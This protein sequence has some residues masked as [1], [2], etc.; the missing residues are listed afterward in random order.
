MT[1]SRDRKY[2]IVKHDLKSFE[3]LPNM[4]WNTEK[5]PRNIPHRYNSIK[6]GDRWVAF[7][8]TSSDYRERPLSLVT[9]FYECVKE[10]VYTNI[11]RNALPISC[12][13]TK[14]WFIEGKQHGKE[15]KWAVGFPPI[16]KFLKKRHFKNQSIIPI[17]EKEF[18]QIYNYVIN[19]LFNTDGIPILHRQPKNEQEVL[20]IVVGGHKALGIEKILQVQKAF[21]D[22]LV[23][24]KNH[25]EPVYLELEV[26]SQNFIQHKHNKGVR[27]KKFKDAIPVAVL[28]WV[29][30]D[31]EVKKYVHKVF[32]ISEL[33][34]EHKTIQW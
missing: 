8:F 22:L 29:D 10:R 17:S 20:S 15:I 33:L 13:E 21:P 34:R 30:N 1:D 23:K 26:Y 27:D 4:I 32:E 24:I 18:Q 7:A 3:A 12:G 5:G 31:S 16:D 6:E 19:H 28:C 11:P 2:Y 14:A 25:P 9:G